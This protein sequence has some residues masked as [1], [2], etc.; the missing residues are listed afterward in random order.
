MKIIR[1]VRK[2]R[3]IRLVGIAAVAIFLTCATA[4][5]ER[6]GPEESSFGNVC[7]RLGSD[8]CYVPVLNAGFPFSFLVDEPY[9]S[10]PGSLDLGEFHPFPFLL[11]VVVF[12]IGIT[13]TIEVGKHIK[14][15]GVSLRIKLVG[16]I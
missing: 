1:Q 13:V 10:V 12:A 14:Q 3:V 9:I 11:D 8:L 2:S 6:F 7:G 4:R 16:W 15:T 5:Y